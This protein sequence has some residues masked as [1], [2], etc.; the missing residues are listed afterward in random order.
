[1]FDRHADD[2]RV[3]PQAGDIQPEVSI[4]IWDRAGYD[5]AAKFGS[6]GQS[7]VA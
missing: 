7:L 1:M 2:Q 5:P 4:L 3:R 6:T